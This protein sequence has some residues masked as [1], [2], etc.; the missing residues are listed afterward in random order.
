MT[1]DRMRLTLHLKPSRRE[2]RDLWQQLSKHFS[3]EQ[4]GEVPDNVCPRCGRF[5]RGDRVGP[6]QIL[7]YRCHLADSPRVVRG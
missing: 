7:C 3:Q 6:D 4:Q 1:H 5:K 2:A